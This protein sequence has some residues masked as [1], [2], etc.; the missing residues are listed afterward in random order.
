MSEGV[1]ALSPLINKHTCE[2]PEIN[3]K[4]LGRIHLSCG[5]VWFYLKD[6]LRIACLSTDNDVINMDFKV[7]FK[8]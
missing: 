1:A 7:E 2:V 8:F 5:F 4:Y 3:E 6:H